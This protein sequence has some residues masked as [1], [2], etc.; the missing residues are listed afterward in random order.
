MFKRRYGC[1]DSH[2]SVFVSHSRALWYRS[3]T[4]SVHHHSPVLF[5][6]SKATLQWWVSGC[7]D[8]W[9]VWISHTRPGWWRGQEGS[10]V[11]LHTR[12]NHNCEEPF[13]CHREQKSL[14]AVWAVCSSIFPTTFESHHPPPWSVLPSLPLELLLEI[15]LIPPPSRRKS[16]SKVERSFYSGSPMVTHI[17]YILYQLISTLKYV[18]TEWNTL[19]Y[20]FNGCINPSD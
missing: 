7:V 8:S 3:L 11:S 14:S 9:L 6:L 13:T 5:F 19:Y 18:Y 1:S 10:L 12:A 17:L 15:N 2:S 4:G 20:C 16:N